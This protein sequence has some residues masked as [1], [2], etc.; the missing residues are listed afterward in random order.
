METSKLVVLERNELESVN[1]GIIV[2]LLYYYFQ[3]LTGAYEAG[4]DE[5]L[6]NK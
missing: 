5:G 4:Y 3:A 2:I 6:K 1:G